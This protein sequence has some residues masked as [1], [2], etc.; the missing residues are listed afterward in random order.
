LSRPFRWCKL[1]TI[2]LDGNGRWKLNGLH[3]VL[4]LRRFEFIDAMLIL[5]AIAFDHFDVQSRKGMLWLLILVGLSL[6]VGID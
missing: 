4:F 6:I 2:V 5:I 3:P 1:W